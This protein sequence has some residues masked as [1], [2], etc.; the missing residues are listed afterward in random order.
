MALVSRLPQFALPDIRDSSNSLSVLRHSFDGVALIFDSVPYKLGS[1]KDFT[2]SLY[3][4]EEDAP[5]VVVAI[6][7]PTIGVHAT[8]RKDP[9]V[10][11][12]PCIYCQLSV[13]FE[14]TEQMQA[15]EEEEL[16]T[17]CEIRFAVDKEDD[18]FQIYETISE[19]SALHPDPEDVNDNENEHRLGNGNLFN[20]S[21][22]WFFASDDANELNEAAQAAFAHLE[23]VF[24]TPIRRTPVLEDDENQEQ[25]TDLGN[26]HGS[27]RTASEVDLDPVIRTGQFSDA[28]E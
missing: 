27:K 1:L 26:G 21:N 19:C 17:G 28:K 7:Y 24:D 3:C 15:D 8:N 6:E 18:L 14:G 2:G 20:G 16:W 9:F 11:D 23:T 25:A 10:G 5:D 13:S 4:A 22:E 12:K